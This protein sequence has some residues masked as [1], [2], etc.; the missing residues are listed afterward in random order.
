MLLKKKKKK[1]KICELL[2]AFRFLHLLVELAFYHNADIRGN[3]KN[4]WYRGRT[5]GTFKGESFAY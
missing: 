2:V 3:P 4:L 5:N 1:K